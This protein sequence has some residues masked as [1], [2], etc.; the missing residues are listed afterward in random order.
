MA[1]YTNFLP[2]KKVFHKDITHS[3]DLKEIQALIRYCSESGICPIIDFENNKISLLSELQV[4]ASDLNDDS[5]WGKENHNDKIQTEAKLIYLYAELNKYTTVTESTIA[6]GYHVNG[7]TLIETS[8]SNRTL[9]WLLFTTVV[10][11]LAA[12]FNEI[13]SSWLNDIVQAEEGWDLRLYFI[14]EHVLKNLMPFVWGGLGACMYL[15]M[16]LYEIARYRAFDQTRLHGW[17]LRVLLGSI[18]AAV[19]VFIFNPTAF[20]TDELPLESKSLAFLTGLGVKVV[21]G[22]FEKVVDTLVDKFNLDSMKNSGRQSSVESLRV[23]ISEMIAE[24]D[25]EDEETKKALIGVLKK[26]KS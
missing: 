1:F 17:G 25:D 5:K 16:A 24:L 2:S 4:V 26:V 19:V 7:R 23:L 8:R 15:S 12:A 3:Y 11:V 10:L 21:F 18:L 20:S 22:A 14:R 6:D 9:S 13:L